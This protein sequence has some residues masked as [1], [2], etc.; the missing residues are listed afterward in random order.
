MSE[1]NFVFP[2]SNEVV[3]GMRHTYPARYF[4]PSEMRCPCD[5][6][7]SDSDVQ[8]SE[9]FL[10]T[11]DNLR[12]ACGFP[13]IVNSAFRCEAHN[14]AVGG[15]PNSYH[16]KGRAVDVSIH[17]LF[18]RD[19]RKLAYWAAVYKLRLIYYDDFVH[20][21]NGDNFPYLGYGS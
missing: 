7:S 2:H 10:T 8:F 15:V 18:F 17:D 9:G 4:T 5:A 19:E 14:K 11:L 1:L 3:G 13:F 6:C 20:I 12:A 21:D 16:L